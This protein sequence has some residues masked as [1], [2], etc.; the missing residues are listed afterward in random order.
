M[1]GSQR[2]SVTQAPVLLSERLRAVFNAIADGV[3]VADER[4]NLLDWNPAARRLHGFETVEEV[5]Q[6]LAHFA[7][8]FE[9]APPGGGPPLPLDQW[10]LARALRGETV[11]DCVLAVTRTDVGLHWVISYSAA[12]IPADDPSGGAE[13]I[14]L[15][16]RDLTGQHLA[17]AASARAKAQLRQLIESL[18]QLVW[19]CRPTAPAT[20]SARSG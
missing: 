18:P 2:Q 13:L 12:R 4:G 10:P 14:V 20:T 19:T 9:L 17:E 8:N 3:I 7:T 6:P 15:T 1:S 5:L 11:S 16:L